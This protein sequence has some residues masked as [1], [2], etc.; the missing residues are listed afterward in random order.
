VGVA[1]VLIAKAAV[2]KGLLV[3]EAARRRGRRQVEGVKEISQGGRN[4]AAQQQQPLSLILAMGM[5]P[6]FQLVSL[7]FI[8][9]GAQDR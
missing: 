6:R 7:H 8:F 5:N 9:C 4:T 3:A 1:A 2:V